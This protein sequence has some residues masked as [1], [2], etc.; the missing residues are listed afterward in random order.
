MGTGQY[1]CLWFRRTNF[2][3]LGTIRLSHILN[4]GVALVVSADAPDINCNTNVFRTVSAA[5]QAIPQIINYPI[6]MEIANFGQLGNLILSN[7]KFGPRGS[8]EII[9]RN[10]ATDIPHIG[11]LNSTSMFQ[12]VSGF[13]DLD[14]FKGFDKYLYTSS[15]Q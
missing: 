8:L 1:A 9:N 13:P 5:V 10:F 6:I 14:N 15:N 2:L 7:Y 4:S 12:L 3:S 11:I